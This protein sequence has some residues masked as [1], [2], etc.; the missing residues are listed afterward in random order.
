MVK[1]KSVQQAADEQVAAA[2]AGLVDGDTTLPIE[3]QL[4][5]MIADLQGQE[6]VSAINVFQMVDVAGRKDLAFVTSYPLETWQDLRANL[7]REFG[8]GEFRIQ[9][10]AHGAFVVNKTIPVIRPPNWKPPPAAAEPAPAIDGQLQLA[11]ATM[12]ESLKE[13]KAQLATPPAQTR[14]DFLEEMRL[15]RDL[16]APSSPAPAFDPMEAFM[17][18]LTL[19]RELIPEGGGGGD[20]SMNPMALF[21]TIAETV[22]SI[23]SMQ[24][25]GAGVP[26]I[27]APKSNVIPLKSQAV[28]AAVTV[29]AAAP[30]GGTAA[31]ESDP[32]QQTM[33]N[34]IR[35]LVSQAAADNPVGTSADLILQNVPE[36]QLT[37]LLAAPNFVDLLAASVPEVKQHV[38]WFTA[39]R[40]D[41][42]TQ[43]AAATKSASVPTK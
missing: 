43:L 26:A 41:L 2:I 3:V 7:Q 23:A 9:I 4:A 20:S 11:M 30:A 15:T 21:K 33:V 39:L 5:D 19:A 38:A 6:G 24:Q 13:L 40:D 36:E 14:A 16:F 42:R 31:P 27:A 34:A 25:P 35:F 32:M 12:A 10:R 29:P 22:Q 37:P 18:G 1:A 28:S 8:G 17:R